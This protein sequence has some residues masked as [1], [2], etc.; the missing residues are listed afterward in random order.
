MQ[1]KQKLEYPFWKTPHF[2]VKLLISIKLL[3][4]GILTILIENKIFN[5]K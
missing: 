1:I 3:K 5:K 2:F 4:T